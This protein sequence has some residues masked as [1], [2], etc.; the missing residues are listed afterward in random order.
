MFGVLSKIGLDTKV[1]FRETQ[2]RTFPSSDSHANTLKS[3]VKGHKISK[4]RKLIVVNFCY[5]LN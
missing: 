2:S 1:I 3:S 4:R 5:F